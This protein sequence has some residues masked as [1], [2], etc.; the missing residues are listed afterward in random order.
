[1]RLA[2]FI[3]VEMEQ[4]LGGWEEAAPNTVPELQGND[5]RALKDQ[6]REILELVTQNLDTSQPKNESARMALGNGKSPAPGFN[7][8][9]GPSRFQQNF[10]ILQMIR[11]LRARVTRAW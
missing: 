2:Q 11:E 6:A 3:Q 1:M 10:S 5:S 9:H 4:L 7:S 8:D